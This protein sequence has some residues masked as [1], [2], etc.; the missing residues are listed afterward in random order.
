MWLQSCG[1]LSCGNF[2]TPNGNPETKNH[3]DVVPVESCKVY[4]KGEGG[5]FP[6]VWVV[7]S[8]VSSSCPWLVLTTKVL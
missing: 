6:Q 5:D 3:L 4:Y 2:G 1:S 8:L 7:V